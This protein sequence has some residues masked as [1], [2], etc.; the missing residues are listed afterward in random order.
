MQD[1]SKPLCRFRT[2]DDVVE[3]LEAESYCQRAIKTSG[4]NAQAQDGGFMKPFEM[5]KPPAKS[6]ARRETGRRKA[7][8]KR[9]NSKA[10]RK[11]GQLPTIQEYFADP[12]SL[13]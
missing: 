5:L 3:N 11:N 7:N 10:K 6:E 9:G 8:N 1:L 4:C 12:S 13:T 2:N